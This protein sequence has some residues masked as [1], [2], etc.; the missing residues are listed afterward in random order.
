MKL[1]TKEIKRKQPK[2]YATESIP[3]EEKEVVCKF[4]NPIGSGDWYVL[5]GEE[6]EG[7]FM[8]FGLVHL[9]ERT[10]DIFLLRSWRKQGS[11]LG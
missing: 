7:D 11:L 9:H 1:L 3:L 5:E 10:L 6:Q 2:L 8:F 4:F